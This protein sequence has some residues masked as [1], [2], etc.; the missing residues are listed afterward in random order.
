MYGSIVV[1]LVL[2][3]I[4]VPMFL[5]HEEQVYDHNPLKEFAAD[6]IFE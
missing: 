6:I 3:V 4:V 2:S 1:I 5:C